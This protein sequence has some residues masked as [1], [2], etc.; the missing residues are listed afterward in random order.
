MPIQAENGH[1]GIGDP[2]ATS[3]LEGVGCQHHTPAVLPL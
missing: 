3:S 2:F 1:G